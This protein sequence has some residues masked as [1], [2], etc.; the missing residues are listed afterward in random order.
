M[1]IRVK[2]THGLADLDTTKI[3]SSLK[4]AGVNLSK[5]DLEKVYDLV[6]KS[7]YDEITTDEII[8][9]TIKTSAG[10]IGNHYDY[11]YLTA[12]LM[13]QRL[14]KDIFKESVYEE[15]NFYSEIYIQKFDEYLDYGIGIGLIDPT[16][17]TFDLPKIKAAIKPER[18]LLFK[19]VAMGRILNQY[20]LKTNTEPQRVFELPQYW[21]MRVAMGLSISEKENEKTDKAIQFY[22]TLSTLKVLSSTPTLLNSGRV[23]NQCSSCFLTYVEDSL[24]GIMEGISDVAYLSKYA[25]GLGVD[26]SAV[27]ATGSL[28]KGTNGKSLGIIPFLKTLDSLSAAVNQGGVRK[29]AVM[30]SIEPWHA[31]IRDFISIKSVQVEENRRASNLHTALWIPDLFMKRV[32]AKAD[33][34]LFS[35]SD[36]PD[37]HEKYGKDFENAYE[38]YEKNPNIPQKKVSA[39]ELWREILVHLLGKGFGHPWVTF[40][41]ACNVRSPQ[42]HVG[43]I[44]S[45][46]L[47]TE[48]A[49][50][51]SRDETA[52]CN[53]ASINLS[54]FVLPKP[55]ASQIVNGKIDPVEAVDWEDL[56][57]AIKQS[58][59]MLDNVIDTNFYATKQAENANK[60]H[61]PV[62]LGVMGYQDMIQQLNIPFSS[63]ES[64][65]FSDKLFEFISYYSIEASSEISAEKGEYS[66]YKGSKWDRSIFPLDTLKLYEEERGVKIQTDFTERLNWQELK[67]FVKQNGMRNSQLLAIAPTRSISYIAGTSPS[68][69]PWDS[70]LFT[71]VGMTGK[72]TLI[73]DRLLDALE[74]KGLWTSQMMDKIRQNGGSVQDIPEI[75]TEIKEEYKT[76]Y[77]VHPKFNI[78]ANARRQKW[79]D[80]A[81]SFNQWLPN[82]N[83]SDAEKIYMECWK[84]GLKSTYYLHTRSGSMS[85]KLAGSS[86]EFVQNLPIQENLETNTGSNFESTPEPTKILAD[87]TVCDRTDPNCEACQ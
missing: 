84:A 22:N 82:P 15:E 40:K 63:Q 44:H 69:E 77:E 28:I 57:L 38:S 58:I 42:D 16:L 21:M 85:E 64:V 36:V 17:K 31:D 33:W 51:T 55:H 9:L 81:I 80:M 53:L 24:E 37:L 35:P 75:P 79:V 13:L 10:F 87:G 70:N 73:N 41:D 78:A 8:T 1:T 39:Q 27:R 52:V 4:F 2:T 66:T 76:A 6:V 45:T 49:L 67:D 54:Q 71:E 46:N 50:N 68:I 20:L 62:G 74:E 30:A 11:S 3:R 56:K 23:R 83:G 26:W 86:Q 60:R 34:T 18:D 59:R 7:L 61:R 72:Y 5:V 47:C 65:E 29:G 14:Y 43:V 12:R 19:E 25:G 32:E 48:V